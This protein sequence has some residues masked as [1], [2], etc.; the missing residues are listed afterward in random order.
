MEGISRAVSNR[1]VG[2]LV[3]LYLPYK[4]TLTKFFSDRQH[5]GKKLALTAAQRQLQQWQRQYPERG[6]PPFYAQPMKHNK[7]GVNGVSETYQRVK[8]TGEKIPCFSVYY[9]LG[10]QRC[11]KRFYLH[12]YDSRQA[13]LADATAFRQAMEKVMWKEWQSAKRAQARAKR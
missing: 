7:L 5:G 9:K 11:T 4:N 2:W 12:H 13:A 1:A 8:S 10:E 3:R 6:R